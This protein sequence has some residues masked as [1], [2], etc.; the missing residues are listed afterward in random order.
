MSFRLR[1]ELPAGLLGLIGPEGA[2]RIH[3]L[4]PLYL[5]GLCLAHREERQTILGL[6]RGIE[7]ELGWV[8]SYRVEQ[9]QADW[10]LGS[11]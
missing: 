2:V 5:V 7:A 10:N 8:T 6:L 4:Q 11:A 3:M 9:L 1:A